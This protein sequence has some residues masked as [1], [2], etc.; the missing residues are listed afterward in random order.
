MPKIALLHIGTAK[1]GTTS[2]QKWLADA[3]QHGSLAPVSY[4]LWSGSHNQQR[5]VAL[6]KPYEDLPPL[7]RQNYGPSGTRYRR[8]CERYRQYLFGELRAAGGAVI[9][10]E[11]L[12]GLFSPLLATRLREDLESLGFMQFHVV[13]YVRDPADF[14]LSNTQQALKMTTRPPFVEDPASFRYEFLRMTETWEQAFPGRL[15]VRK[16]PTEPHYDVVDD[17]A[18]V[19]QQCLSVAPPRSPL[20]TNT[21]ISAEGMQILQ[22]YR[23]SFSPDIG[24]NL[25][26]DA[27]KLVSF[28]SESADGLPQTKPVLKKEVAE[29]IRA[30]HRADAEVLYARYGVDLSLQNYLPAAALPRDDFDRIDEI[31]ESVDPEVVHR[32][33]LLLAKTELSHPFARQSLA[34]R[35]ASRAYRYIPPANRPE[36]LAHWLRSQ[37]T[38]G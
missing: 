15:I 6:Y 4:P 22:D 23:Q 20:R 3:Q 12:C 38:K 21:T 25:T 30:N 26:P 9:S 1:T 37:L 10:A 34:F 7:M 27:A 24:G 11:S 32:L 28:L 5:L 14:F 17:F 35:A 33:L 8:M 13:L 31:L 29:Q 16:F 2:I 18:A 36:R 19:L